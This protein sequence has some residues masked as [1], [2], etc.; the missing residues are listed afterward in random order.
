[1]AGDGSG[2]AME[3]LLK[4]TTPNWA[5]GVA[6]HEALASVKVAGAVATK[7]ASYMMELANH[8]QKNAEELDRAR[9]AVEK[10]IIGTPVLE[11]HYLSCTDES[12]S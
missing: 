5:D 8:A 4:L 11:N 1:M 2:T 7:A 3:T 6:G 12:C 9:R 10:Y